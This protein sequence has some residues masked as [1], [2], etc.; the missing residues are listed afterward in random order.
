MDAFNLTVYSGNV[1]W[2]GAASWYFTV[3]ARPFV[4]RHVIGE[5][6]T[7]PASL[8]EPVVYASRF[9][10]G[11][12]SAMALMSFLRLWSEI[13]N[14]SRPA[15]EKKILKEADSQVFLSSSLGHFS[16]WVFN[17]VPFILF[18][19]NRLDELPLRFTN[20]MKLIFGLDAFMAVLNYA[21]FKRIRKA[22]K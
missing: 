2:F 12:N 13:V 8:R 5:V 16:Q 15:E 11:M 17:V 10:G 19:Q 18:M 9:L 20:Q 21:A 1:A 3:G 7:G 14:R 6:K 22:T 4:K